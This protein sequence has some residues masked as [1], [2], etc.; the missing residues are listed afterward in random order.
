MESRRSRSNAHILQQVT[1]IHVIHTA[2]KHTEVLYYQLLTEQKSIPVSV[3]SSSVNW[4][5]NVNYCFKFTD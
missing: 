1:L 2:R 3:L 4:S 5:L